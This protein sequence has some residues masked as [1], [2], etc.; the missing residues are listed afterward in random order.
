[1]R[2]SFSVRSEHHITLHRKSHHSLHLVLSVV[3]PDGRARDRWRP[4]SAGHVCV[5]VEGVCSHYR[6]TCP[7]S[8]SVRNTTSSH[9]QDIVGEIPMPSHDSGLIP[10]RYHTF[11]SCTILLSWPLLMLSIRK[12]GPVPTR[13][14]W[15]WT[16]DQ[17]GRDARL[18]YLVLRLEDGFR[19][20]YENGHFLV[21]LPT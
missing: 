18:R 8:K 1:M 4:Y 3:R 19:T 14:R 7:F 5:R 15:N 20:F 9:T 11:D 21:K 2:C 10:A 17:A 13:L 6:N 16:K 12:H